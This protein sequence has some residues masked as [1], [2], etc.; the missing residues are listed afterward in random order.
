MKTKIRFD[1]LKKLANHL[2]NGVLGHTHFKFE[3]YTSGKRKENGCGTAGCAIGECPIVFPGSWEFKGTFMDFVT[4]KDRRDGS[5]RSHGE[6]FFGLSWLEYSHLFVPESQDPALY[7]GRELGDKARRGSVAK[8]IF[9]F[10][11]K[12]KTK[13]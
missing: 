12:M 10:I 2:L 5:T 4:L 1:R 13:N 6:Y 7:G 8:N 3:T 9:A 11:D